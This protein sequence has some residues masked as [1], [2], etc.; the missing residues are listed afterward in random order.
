MIDGMRIE[1]AGE[2]MNFARSCT[3]SALPEKISFTA[4]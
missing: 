2:A 4:R 3:I 1:N